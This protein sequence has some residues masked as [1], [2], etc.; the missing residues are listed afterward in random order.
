MTIGEKIRMLRNFR[1]MSQKELGSAMGFGKNG[2]DN[3]ITQ[4]ENNYRIP[5]KKI[6]GEIAR[7]LRVN[8]ELFRME[9]SGTLQDFIYA[10]LWMNE[11]SPGHIH[12]FQIKQSADSTTNPIAIYFDLPDI[13][14]FL[15]D[16]L[17][18]EQELAEGKISADDFREWKFSR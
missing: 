13:N 16:W 11:E 7:V 10:L 15:S 8:P 1:G 5:D 6:L 3:R 4:Y 14:K 17:S 18:H 2:S 12:L 9:N